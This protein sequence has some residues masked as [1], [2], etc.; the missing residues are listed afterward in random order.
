MF[1]H[2]RRISHG[3]NPQP[4]GGKDKIHHQAYKVH[5]DQSWKQ[6]R[7]H[8]RHVLDIQGEGLNEKMKQRFQIINVCS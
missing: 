4:L 2:L 5:V 1:N 7:E 6:V 3:K 8:V